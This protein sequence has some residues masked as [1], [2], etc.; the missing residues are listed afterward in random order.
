LISFAVCCVQDFEKW[1]EGYEVA[2]ARE[3]E[4]VWAAQQV[5]KMYRG[6]AVRKRGLAAAGG[7][8]SPSA[9]EGKP[10]TQASSLVAGGAGG[11][12]WDTLR[13]KTLKKYRAEDTVGVG[14][15]EISK[16]EQLEACRQAGV[17][18]RDPEVRHHP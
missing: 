10:P 17:I 8:S 7:M 2:A 5:Q 6:H 3:L 11:A 18:V 14:V 4:E 16:A 15:D 12:G 9:G 13:R 1:W